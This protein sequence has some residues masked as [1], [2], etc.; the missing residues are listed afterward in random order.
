MSNHQINKCDNCEKAISDDE[1]I[2]LSQVE[3]LLERIDPGGTVPIGECPDCGALAYLTTKVVKI[4]KGQRTCPECGGDEFYRIG[5]DQYVGK[6]DEK[7]G[8][9]NLT[10]N[11]CLDSGPIICNGCDVEIEDTFKNVNY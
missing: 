2:P 3:H 1:L 10:T 9:L 5:E 6:I 7:D 11:Y 4:P 8:E